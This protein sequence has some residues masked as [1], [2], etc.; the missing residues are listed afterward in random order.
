M[1]MPTRPRAVPNQSI[2]LVSVEVK[3]LAPLETEFGIKEP[4]K[5][6]VCFS[7]DPWMSASMP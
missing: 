1:V 6:S 3:G 5:V 7:A 4:L 2:L